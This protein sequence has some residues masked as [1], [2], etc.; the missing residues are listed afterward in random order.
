MKDFLKQNGILILIIALLLTLIGAVLSFT[1]GGVAN[2]FANLA[3]VVTTPVR[4]GIHTVVE[5]A[6]GLY[7]DAF[8]REAMARE[9]EELRQENA[10]LKAEAREGEEASRENQRLRD[11]LD[12]QQKRTDLH[13]EPAT[14]T[15]RGSS[16]WSSTLTVS[17]GSASQ[18]EAGDCVIDQYGNL[19]GIISEVGLNWSTLITVVDVD[20]ELGGLIARTDGAAIIEGDFTLMG[21]G[22]LKLTYLPE[23]TRLLAGDEIL[24][25]GLRSG[26]EATYPSGILVGR[27]AEV[28]ADEG[29][30][31]EY[32]VLTPA[33]NLDKLE[34]VFIIKEFEVIE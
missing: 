24:T 2:P 6:E 32:A 34:Q 18:V 14:V 21:Q 3:G 19:V 12:F 5:W 26:G 10:R 16:N 31:S 8:E 9:L 7:S 15:A 30:M 23:G 13:T 27:V 11:L 1:F 28:R 29:G 22:R 33:T 25:S 17:K 20:L 4:N